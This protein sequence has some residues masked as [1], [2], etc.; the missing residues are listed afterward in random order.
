[1]TDEN[2]NNN[3][4]AALFAVMGQLANAARKKKWDEMFLLVNPQTSPL[5]H[6]I[7]GLGDQPEDILRGIVLTLAELE[8][9]LPPS[10]DQAA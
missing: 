6:S 4:L 9:R 1:M 2:N 10:N 3:P 5:T 7:R 8:K